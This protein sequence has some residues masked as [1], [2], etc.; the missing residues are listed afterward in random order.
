M[1]ENELLRTRLLDGID[2]GPARPSSTKA[3]VHKDEAGNPDG[4]VPLPPTSESA[5][6]ATHHHEQSSSNNTTLDPSTGHT[7]PSMA[8]DDI[9]QDQI[10]DC[11]ALYV[12]I[13]PAI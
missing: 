1:R 7:N 5:F 3:P 9:G 10:R 6:E 2:I 13:N 12:C 4:I 8:S 11:F